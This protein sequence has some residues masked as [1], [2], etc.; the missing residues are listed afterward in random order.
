MPKKLCMN[1]FFSNDFKSEMTFGKISAKILVTVAV[2]GGWFLIQNVSDFLPKIYKNISQTL[3]DRMIISVAHG[4]KNHDA[5]LNMSFLYLIS[6]F[7]VFSSNF[8][9]RYLSA[10]LKKL[11]GKTEENITDKTSQ[12]QRVKF[13]K[14]L[15]RIMSLISI[16]FACIVIISIIKVFAEVEIIREFNRKISIATPYIDT[17]QK[18][19]I[20]SN[21]ALMKGENDYLK[22]NA[23]L[24]SIFKANKLTP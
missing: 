7:V 23:K 14:R 2:A 17:K 18:E 6:V 10:R 9:Y 19:I 13:L 8:L 4:P 24:D 12:L 5:I 1:N 16:P 21:F 3:Y 11:N 20:I 22:I 15:A